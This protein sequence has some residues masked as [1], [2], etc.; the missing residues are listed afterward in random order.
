MDSPAGL[1]SQ[2]RHKLHDAWDRFH[3]ETVAQAEVEP[4]A[5]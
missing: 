5:A 1:T 2:L 4:V 3:G